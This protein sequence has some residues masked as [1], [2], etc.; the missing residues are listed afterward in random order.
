MAILEKIPTTAVTPPPFDENEQQS[1]QQHSVGSRILT[2]ARSFPIP[3]GVV[4]LLLVS[5]G[6]WITGHGNLAHWP[7]LAVILLGGLPLLWETLVQLWHREFGVDLIAIIAIFGSLFEGEYLA[8]SLVV[9][10]L[11]GG[12]ALE[13]FALSRARQ[14]LSALADRAPRVAHIWSDNEL[15]SIAAEAVTVGMVIVVKPGEIIP[16]DGVIR[17]GSSSIS[18]ADLTGEPTP[19]SKEPGTSVMSGS[20]N[21]DGVLEIEALHPSSESKYAQIVKL[22]QEAQENKAPIHRLADQYAVG[23]TFFALVMAALAWIISGNSINALAV[24]V[25]ATPCPLILATPIAIMSGIGSAARIGVI[26][27]SGSAI[28]QLGGVD[29]AIFDKTGT[30]TLGLP[31]VT[32][33]S[34]STTAK[35]NENTILSLAASVEQVSS[36]VLA[37]SVVT[38]A[39]ERGLPVAIATGYQETVGKGASGLVT[40]LPDSME[41]PVAIGNRTY[42]LS[43]DIQVPEE[44]IAERERRSEVGEITSYIAID[45]HVEGLVVMADVPRPEIAQLMTDL[46]DSGIVETILL[47]GDTEVVAAKVGQMA[48]V[49][50]VVARCLPDDKVRVIRELLNANHHVLT[51][52]DGVNDAPALATASVGMAMGTQGLTAASVAADAVLLSPNI[53]RVATSVQIGRWVMH[54]AR[55]GIWIGMALSGIAMVVAAFGYLPP[56]AGALLQEGIDVLVI[57]N[58]LRAGQIRQSIPMVK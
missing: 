9:L 5:A 49:D 50:R 32:G 53:Q 25:V 28:E 56:A 20:V 36:H 13:S 24:I 54:V 55:Q 8:G 21:L 39:H 26:V 29:V 43:L 22:V 1:D 12:E 37:K 2:F 31:Q 17:K 35:Y 19:V 14:S 45:R 18:E 42:M 4:I 23:F 15:I 40:L 11:S 30:L 16:V 44:L 33:F 6:L 10:M 34:L 27:K 52:G 48:H 51:V 41:H 38:A 3:S 58:A 57:M 7:M 46:K 47:T